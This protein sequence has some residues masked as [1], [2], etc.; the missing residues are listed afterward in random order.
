MRAVVHLILLLNH[1]DYWLPREDNRQ[2]TETTSQL[3]VCKRCAVGRTGEQEMREKPLKT[4]VFLHVLA[5]HVD[6]KG[7]IL[8]ARE[9]ADVRLC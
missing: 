3:A 5:W 4:L 9:V 7:A 8:H 2:F 1:R 6:C